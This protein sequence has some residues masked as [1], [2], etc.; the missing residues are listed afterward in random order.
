MYTHNLTAALLPIS[1]VLL[2]G[3][4]S[5]KDCIP[6]KDTGRS[7]AGEVAMSEPRGSQASGEDGGQPQRPFPEEPVLQ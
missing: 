2:S 7:V 5:C 6:V 4:R 1:P 3:M